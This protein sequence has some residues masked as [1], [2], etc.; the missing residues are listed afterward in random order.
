[1][2]RGMNADGSTAIAATTKKVS[3]TTSITGLARRETGYSLMIESLR[4]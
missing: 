1:M 2:E 3:S 4:T